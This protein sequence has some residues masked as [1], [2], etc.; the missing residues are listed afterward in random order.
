MFLQHDF[1]KFRISLFNLLTYS[2]LDCFTQLP[3]TEL[4]CPCFFI[5]LSYTHKQSFGWFIEIHMSTCLSVS[6]FIHLFIY[7]H[8]LSS[9]LHPIVGGTG[10]TEP[11]IL[12]FDQNNFEV[13]NSKTWTS[14][15]QCMR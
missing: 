14:P 5:V 1:K 6:S 12:N 4:N 2:S 13:S 7:P 8:L 11:S 10:H 15:L 9:N 3:F